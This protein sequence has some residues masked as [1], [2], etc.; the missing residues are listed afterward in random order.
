MSKYWLKII[1]GPAGSGYPQDIIH[2][3][4]QK[5]AD[6]FSKGEKFF[7]YESGENG[8]AKT[9]YGYGN[10]KPHSLTVV[11]TPRKARDK[12][13]P[14]GVEVEVLERVHPHDGMPLGIVKQI[15]GLQNIQRRGGII[16][17]SADQYSEL[18][19]RFNM[20]LRK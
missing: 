20:I 19:N 12:I 15:L 16:S 2:F 5:I 7:L 14:F 9:V 13:Y 1:Y 17:L 3:T 8:G 6:V 4:E 10:V 11:D 18:L